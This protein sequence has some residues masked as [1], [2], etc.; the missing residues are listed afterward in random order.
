MKVTTRAQ[1]PGGLKWIP[2]WIREAAKPSG[3][4][5]IAGTEELV[6]PNSGCSNRGP[7]TGWLIINRHL[8][9][10]VLE[11]ETFKI[12]V[13]A[14]SVSDGDPLSRCPSFGC[15]FTWTK[16]QGPLLSPYDK[17]SGLRT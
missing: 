17:G 11:A 16:E 8:F 3:E 6:F 1:I 5:V 4:G 13:L 15:T 9:L 12:K 7:Q 14:G 2:L 10:T